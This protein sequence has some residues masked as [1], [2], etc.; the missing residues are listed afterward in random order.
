VAALRVDGDDPNDD[1]VSDLDDVV[2]ALD[3]VTGEELRNMYQAAV[4]EEVD[5]RPV[6]CGAG[7]LAERDRANTRQRPLRTGPGSVTR[8][9]GIRP[10]S[11]EPK[12]CAP[13]GLFIPGPVRHVAG[14]QACFATLALGSL[15]A[16]RSGSAFDTTVCLL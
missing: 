16:C 6:G 7:H 4:A 2:D 1:V 3:T 15:S 8:G 9:K 14:D 12:P 11:A 10:P 13:Q 5:K